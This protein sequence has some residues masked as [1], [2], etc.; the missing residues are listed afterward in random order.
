MFPAV[1]LIYSCSR[2]SGELELLASS[3]L[4][5]FI[6]VLVAQVSSSF[7]LVRSLGC[8]F[9]SSFN[10]SRF[11]SVWELPWSLFSRPTPPLP[12][13]SSIQ[14]LIRWAASFILLASPFRTVQWSSMA[15]AKGT[16]SFF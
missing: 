12:P 14:E 8:L 10:L 15:S 5:K 2:R 4:G 16:G 1:L 9:L 7:S 6:H 13:G 3:L 11:C